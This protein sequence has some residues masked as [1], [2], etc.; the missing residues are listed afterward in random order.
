MR[1]VAVRI[2]AIFVFAIG[3][4]FSS[5]VRAECPDPVLACEYFSAIVGLPAV[6]TGKACSGPDCLEMLKLSEA[7]IVAVDDEGL[8][9]KTWQVWGSGYLV[10]YDCVE[11][12]D[13]RNKKIRFKVPDTNSCALVYITNS[14][15]VWLIGSD[16]ASDCLG[17]CECK[18]LEEE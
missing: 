10:N 5:L 3:F 15:Y 12:M 11:P 13:Y 2:A 7:R 1:S 9:P 14:T 6:S 18:V 16:P 8:F 4:G 17:F